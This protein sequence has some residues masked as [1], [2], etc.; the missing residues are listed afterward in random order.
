M[1][2]AL[3]GLLLAVAAACLVGCGGVELARARR[4]VPGVS[5]SASSIGTAQEQATAED[6]D[7]QGWKAFRLTNGMVTLVVVP[8]IGGRI[9][10]YKLGG[11]PFLWNNPS[12]LGEKTASG[13]EKA[14]WRD[15]GGYKAWPAPQAKWTPPPDPGAVALEGAPWTGK[16]TVAEGRAAEVEMTSPEDRVTGLQFTRTIQLYGGSSR[17]KVTEKLTNKAAQAAEWSVRQLTQ[18]PGVVEAGSN[19]GDKSRLYLPLNP[20]SKLQD[21]YRLE[22]TAGASQFKVLTDKLLQVAYQ[23]QNGAAF[24]DSQAGWVAHVDEAHGY[25]FVQR[26]GIS[27]LG[28]YP[29][30]GSTAMVRVAAQE[31]YLEVSLFSP[32]RTLQPGDSLEVSTDWYAAHVAGPIV[33][34]SDVA[35]VREPLKLARKD[36]KL[37]LTGVLGVFAP[38]NL[39]LN[40]QDG[41]GTAVGQPKLV[42]V[43]PADEVKLDQ[44]VAEEPT[45][46]KLVIELQNANGTPLGEVASLDMGVMVAKAVD[47]K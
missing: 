28:T 5:G 32:L 39:A 36:E 25:A 31:A 16:I 42:K 14:A 3:A 1:N 11:H 29:E 18:V 21:G 2:R 9:M 23:G 6:F 30:Q 40:L 27:P 17:V 41:S 15:Y 35:A 22:G 45:A 19:A 37:R 38:G 8:E 33:S 13:D 4:E 43:S 12:Q 26:F 7:Y 47:A 10:E 44:E 46:K 34:C 24:V 20:E